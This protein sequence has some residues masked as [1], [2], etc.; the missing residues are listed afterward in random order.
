MRLRGRSA[1]WNRPSVC[2]SAHWTIWA[3]NPRSK[4]CAMK[5]KAEKQYRDQLRHAQVLFGRRQLEEAERVLIQG[6]YGD[7]R[8][9]EAL[10]EAVR[11]RT[12]RRRGREDPGVGLRKGAAIDSA[13]RVRAGG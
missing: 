5:S 7:R 12:R 4:R 2:S 1:S 3:R 8:E 10:L 11:A 9:A 13:T 6:S